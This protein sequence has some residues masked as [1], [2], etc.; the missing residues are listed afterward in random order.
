MNLKY[1]YIICW[2]FCLTSGAEDNVTG[3][4]KF[5]FILKLTQ[6]LHLVAKINNFYGIILLVRHCS[7]LFL[8]Q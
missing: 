1:Y 4:S 2:A 5:I 7:C 3:I 8:Q 6:Y